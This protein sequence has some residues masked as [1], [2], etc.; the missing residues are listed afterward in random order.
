MKF[1][2]DRLNSLGMEITISPSKDVRCMKATYEK[3]NHDERE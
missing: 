1:S 3:K 2:R